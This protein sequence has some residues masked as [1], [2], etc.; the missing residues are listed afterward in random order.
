MMTMSSDDD[1]D[2]DKN[3]EAEFTREDDK[4]SKKALREEVVTSF[5]HY[6]F[7]CDSCQVAPI[8]GTRWNCSICKVVDLC[9]SCKCAGTFMSG[10]HVPTHPFHEIKEAQ[11]D[12]GMEN[13]ASYLG[14]T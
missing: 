8:V 1:S 7:T 13:P 14:W 3:L 9:D 5:A 10:E 12:M 11:V 2:I 4:V 6:N